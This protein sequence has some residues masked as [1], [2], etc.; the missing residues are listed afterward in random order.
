MEKKKKSKALIITLIILTILAIVIFLIY[1]NKSSIFGSED[2]TTQSTTNIFQSLFSS[3]KS[4]N[5]KVIDTLNSNEDGVTIN[6]EAGESISKGDLLYSIGKNSNGDLIV[7]KIKSVLKNSDSDILD[8]LDDLDVTI[9]GVAIEDID[10]GEIGEILVP[11]FSLYDTTDTILDDLED[12]INSVKDW[13]SSILDSSDYETDIYN[14][15]TIDVSDYSTECFINGE[16]IDCS[17]LNNYTCYDSEGN[18]LNCFEDFSN[19]YSCLKNGEVVDCSELVDV[20]CSENGEVVD[21]SELVD[22]SDLFPT[23]TV[24][25]SE[26]N[27][28]IGKSST[29]YWTST[30]AT[31]C[32]RD[33]SSSVDISGSFDTGSL[34][35][36]TTFSIIC[37]G[38]YGS[39]YGSVTIVVGSEIDTTF[40]TV[41]VYSSPSAI[42]EGEYSTIYWSSTDT[43]YCIKDDGTPIDV[44][45]SFD[46]DVLYESTSYTIT[47]L[48]EDNGS[49]SGSALVTVGSSYSILYQCNDGEDN[50]GDG[51]I[52][53]DDPSCHTD[54]DSSNSDTYEP[55]LYESRTY[56]IP[57]CS[58]TVDN[59]GD[60][61]IDDADPECYID[62]VY[63]P[64]K[65]FES[66]SIATT[67][68]LP[69]CSDEIDNDDD[70]YIDIDDPECHSD[71]DSSNSDSY[72]PD[73]D[74]EESLSDLYPECSDYED[75]DDDGYIDSEDSACH[76][77]YDSS[78]SD[79]YDPSIDDETLTETD[80]EDECDVLDDYP[81]EFT[82]EEEAE[83][84]ELLSQ[85]YLI[86][87]DLKSENDIDIVYNEIA[88]NTNLV[89][90]AEELIDE[91]YEQTSDS[92]YE[93]PTTRY[94]N[95]WFNSDERG[96]YL[97]GETPETYFSFSY[98][99][100][101]AD[102]ETL[103]E[104]NATKNAFIDYI[105]WYSD[106]YLGSPQTD[107]TWELA[108][109]VAEDI[110]KTYSSY[111]DF[112][113]IFNI[114]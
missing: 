74:S 94:G 19:N 68:S 54:Y 103:Y 105:R 55:M 53:I 64:E 104:T 93:G 79:T 114:W 43:I 83:L 31:S 86:S 70:G 109:L 13:I 113:E 90:E 73:H 5:L 112:E 29:V 21:C 57:E 66:G 108:E 22:E 76:T 77:D 81:L 11:D 24:T 82:E 98:D 15:D 39:S 85:F 111:W 50:D 16:E 2:G 28:E 3:Q 56:Y 32:M 18:E 1:K 45:G 95:P 87:S 48:S 42:S 65:Y 34:D 88:N 60:T 10:S 99:S 12:V 92:E 62:G 9:L 51:Y 49:V 40:P 30:N 44:G 72:L 33:D 25:A 101:L 75:N 91:C 27:I 41:T 20:S 61:Y 97:E 59:D 46:T 67:E 100:I 7:K 96:S 36:S 84:D 110:A 102:F 35:T 4:K 80:S 78:N 26:T 23:V 52:D 63:Y 58:D 47:C 37:S 14:T 38:N 71:D 8:E 89:E 69:E 107:T 106:Q 17:E 6:V